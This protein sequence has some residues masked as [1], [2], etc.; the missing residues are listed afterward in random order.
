MPRESRPGDTIGHDR[1]RPAR[2]SPHPHD[3]PR[4]SRRRDHRDRRHDGRR[5]P[6]RVVLVTVHPRRDGRDR[7]PGHGHARQPPPPG[8][9][10]RR[11]AGAGDGRPGRH[12]M[13]EP[14]L[15]RLRDDGHA[16][17]PRRRAASGRRTS[18]RPPA[19]SSW[20]VRRYQPDVITTYN[21][22]GGY[23]HPDHIRTH[24]RRG[25]RVRP[26][27]RPRLVPGAVLPSTGTRPAARA[28]SSRGR[29]P[30]STSRP[31]RSVRDAMRE[32]MEALGERASGRRPRT[33]RPR[34]SPSGRR[35][36]RACSSRTSSITA[37]VDVSGAARCPLGRDQG[38]RHPDQRR[39]PVRPLRQGGLGEF[40][41][42]EA[43]IRRDLRVPAPDH[44]TDLFGGRGRAEP[45]PTAGAP[46]GARRDD[47]RAV[48]AGG[49][50]RTTA[51][52]AAP[53]RRYRP[54]GSSRRSGSSNPGRPRCVAAR[55]GTPSSRSRYRPP[56]TRDVHLTPAHGQPGSTRRCV[57]VDHPGAKQPGR[58]DPPVG[59]TRA[60]RIRH[61]A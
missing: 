36:R 50:R 52:H 61:C 4:P 17:Q 33:R 47:R 21:D 54:S 45:G 24:L 3:R 55:R 8:R 9:D 40:W 12:R 28:G 38:A 29:R 18:T 25:R 6:G 26:G 19:G 53:R 30:S 27:R 37:W 14:R 2:P 31:S 5:R 41:S 11:R 20:L 39:E 51:P 58:L 1:V 43:F 48:T 35:A 23:G 10:P 34:S 32:R 7:R 46:S 56:A 49:R 22:F 15:P 44:E 60:P 13:G 16:R 57:H 42:R 59:G